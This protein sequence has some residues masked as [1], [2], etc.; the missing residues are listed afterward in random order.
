MGVTRWELR[1]SL[2][3]GLDTALLLVAARF[4]R[5]RQCEQQHFLDGLHEMDRHEAAITLR[6]IEQG[7]RTVAAT[8]GAPDTY[9]SLIR[10][11]LQVNRA[12]SDAQPATPTPGPIILP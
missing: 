5:R 6:A 10:R 12:A 9:L 11:L 2:Q 7:A 4:R 1:V 8:G 3:R